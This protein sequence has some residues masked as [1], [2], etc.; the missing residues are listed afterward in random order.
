MAAIAEMIAKELGASPDEVARWKELVGRLDVSQFEETGEI[1]LRGGPAESG[2]PRSAGRAG[3]DP[4]EVRRILDRMRTRDRVPERK[5]AS[6]R[7]R[8]APGA[9]VAE[10]DYNSVENDLWLYG[11]FS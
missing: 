4:E 11:P 7:R 2:R 5:R 8:R 6:S 3:Y 9:N 10:P 1:V